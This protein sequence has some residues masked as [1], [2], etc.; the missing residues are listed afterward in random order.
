MTAET[1][2]GNGVIRMTALAESIFSEHG[3]G[4]RIRVAIYATDKAI[5]GRMNAI[6]DRHEP[7]M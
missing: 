3:M 7:L 2:D 5:P 4:H 6:V 1:T